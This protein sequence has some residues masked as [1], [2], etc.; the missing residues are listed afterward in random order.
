MSLSARIKRLEESMKPAEQNANERQDM[1]IKALLND[2]ESVDWDR[3]RG[4]DLQ[5]DRLLDDLARAYGTA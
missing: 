1:L 2:P 4:E 3:A 5:M